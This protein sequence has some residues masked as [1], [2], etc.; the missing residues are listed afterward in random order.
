MRVSVDYLEQGYEGVPIP[1]PTEMSHARPRELHAM[2][3]ALH[4]IGTG[5]IN[6]YF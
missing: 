2:A 1:V 6:L 5:K 4:Y 3:Q